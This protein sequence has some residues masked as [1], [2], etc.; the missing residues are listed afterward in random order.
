VARHIEISLERRKIRCAARLL[1][2]DAPRTC[3]A[4]WQ[5]LPQEG[6]VFH[7]KYASNEIYTIVPF[8]GGDKLGNENRTITPIPGDVMYFFLPPGTRLPADAQKLAQRDRGVIDLAVFY[9]RNNL[10]FSPSEGLTPGNV[11]ASIVKGLEDFRTAGHSVWREG[12]VGELLVFRRLEGERLKE[13]G[14][15]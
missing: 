7:A 6:Q 10:L 13:W 8:F 12:A 11:F 5:S 14:L 9:D 4:V 1:D 3:E 15:S 2:D